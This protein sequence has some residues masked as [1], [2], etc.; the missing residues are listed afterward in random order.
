[1]PADRDPCR[2]A[3]GRGVQPQHRR[4]AQS[5]DAAGAHRERHEPAGGPGCLPGIT[6]IDP[7][8]NRVTDAFNAGGQTLALGVVWITDSRDNLLFRVQAEPR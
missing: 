1:V 2:H 3:R 5:P 8:T 4:A 6:R 7:A